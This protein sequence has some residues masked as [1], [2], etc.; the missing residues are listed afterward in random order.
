MCRPSL[1]VKAKLQM[2]TFAERHF[3]AHFDDTCSALPP[4]AGYI[5]WNLCIA[6]PKTAPSLRFKLF[7]PHK[8]IYEFQCSNCV[9]L[10]P[11]TKLRDNSI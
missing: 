3:R 11:L 1:R 7:H 5:V 4:A 2:E 8:P 10:K 6:P 9:F